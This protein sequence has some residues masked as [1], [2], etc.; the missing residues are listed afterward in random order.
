MSTALAEFHFLR[1]AWLYGIPVVVVIWWLW[2]RSTDTLKGW[3][4]QIAPELLEV[5]VV[6]RDSQGDGRTYGLLAAWLL[7]VVAIAGP[8]WRLE[9]NPFAADAQPLMILLKADESMLLA[10]PTP[11]RLK[12]AQLKIAD[13]ALARQGQPLGLI[14]YAGSAHLVLPPTSDTDVVAKMASEITP[15]IMPEPGDRLD[16]AIK[17][18][19]DLLA[20]ELDG[21]SLLVIAD[22][23]EIDAKTASVVSNAKHSFPI[24]FLVLTGKEAPETDRINKAA[25]SLNAS[26]QPLTVDDADISAVVDF[27]E[28]RAASGIA[29]QSRRWQE[30]GYWLTPAI[31]LLVALSFR[32]LKVV[33]R[34][35]M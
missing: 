15:A 31:A 14:A 22:T 19:T 32:R 35:G 1:P 4:A 27:A 10:P 29:G 7:A 24:Q 18:A 17:K 26:L 9:P 8:T 13:L 12:R 28:R 3:R 16:L 21:G 20:D 25:R 6:G 2:R 5:L 34:E 11:S 30:A 23:A 33:A